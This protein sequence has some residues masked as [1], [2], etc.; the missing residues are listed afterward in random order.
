MLEVQDI[1]NSL[2]IDHDLD[3]D[4][5]NQYINTAES[6]I[7]SAINQKGLTEDIKA[8]M[9]Y[10]MAVSLLTQHWYLN[11]QEASSERVPSTV[12]AMIQQ[13]RGKVNGTGQ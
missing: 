4:M 11:R 2:R 13:L 12:T 1:K 8:M 7:Q 6:Y 10:K 3:D 9:Q 5:I